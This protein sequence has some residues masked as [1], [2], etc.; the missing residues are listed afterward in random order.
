MAQWPRIMNT[1]SAQKPR[2]KVYSEP[3]FQGYRV[4]LGAKE[5]PTFGP[6]A[7]DQD[8]ML[9]SDIVPKVHRLP[10]RSGT[11]E[12]YIHPQRDGWVRAE[13]RKALVAELLYLL[14]VVVVVKV[15]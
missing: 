3:S 9:V 2:T 15:G 6:A 7:G 14:L 8:Y 12:D 13:N 10:Q 1:S 11:E 4:L 5:G